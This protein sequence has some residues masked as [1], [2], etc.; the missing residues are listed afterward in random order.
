MRPPSQNINHQMLGEEGTASKK[1]Q[2]QIFDIP[3]QQEQSQHLGNH[4][5][6]ALGLTG[7]PT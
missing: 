2:T 7:L 4:T 3:V 1:T 5:R 6:R